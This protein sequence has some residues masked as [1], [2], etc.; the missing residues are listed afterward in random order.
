MARIGMLKPLLSTIDAR[1]LRPM[2]KVAEA[3]Y[4]TPAHREWRAAVIARANGHCQGKGCIRTGVRLFA[5]HIVELRDGGAPFDVTNGQALCGSCHTV[6][7]V[8]ARAARL[9]GDKPAEPI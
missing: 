4:N 8:N 6:K 7:T 1:S 2:P 3:H 9:R 5:D